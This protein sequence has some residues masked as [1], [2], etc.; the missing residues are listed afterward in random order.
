MN[1]REFL[2]EVQR[3]YDEVKQL[4]ENAPHPIL[5]SFY[6]GALGQIEKCVENARRCAESDP[7]R[8]VAHEMAEGIVATAR[9]IEMGRALMA[10]IPMNLNLIVPTPGDHSLL[11]YIELPGLKLGSWGGVLGQTIRAA[12]EPRLEKCGLFKNSPIPISCVGFD[13]FFFCSI[14]VTDQA[15]AVSVVKTELEQMAL[16]PFCQIGHLDDAN[17]IFRTFYANRT[18]RPFEDC[19]KRV[20]ENYQKV[21]IIP[22]GLPPAR[23]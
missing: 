11:V 8:E 19:L 10:K 3:Q 6:A 20:V 14:E 13:D 12:I 16:L 21:G 4:E 7:E 5:K 1:A 23:M 17:G 15:Q 2:R 9:I 22:S 18:L